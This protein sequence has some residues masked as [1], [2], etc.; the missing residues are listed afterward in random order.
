VPALVSR[1]IY[2]PKDQVFFPDYDSDDLCGILYQMVSSNGFEI[3]AEA[4][5]TAQTIV[6]RI[7]E[8]KG[9]NFGNARE[10]RTFFEAAVQA[11]ADRLASLANISSEQLRVL[12]KVDFEAAGQWAVGRFYQ[13]G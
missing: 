13:A 7:Y 3:A 6:N 2:V 4:L 11:Q 10:M 12:R 5:E 9:D 8:C 1:D